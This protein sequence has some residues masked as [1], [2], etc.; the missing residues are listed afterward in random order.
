MWARIV[1]HAQAAVERL[2]D[3][4]ARAD[5]H[6]GLLHTRG[7]DQERALLH[8]ERALHSAERL[9][10][11]EHPVVA[12]PPEARIRRLLYSPP[13][14]KSQMKPLKHNSGNYGD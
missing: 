10:G 14:A 2:G 6:T 11:P 9:Y 7:R 12:A 8:L 4:G 1:R 3:D 5:K 13:S